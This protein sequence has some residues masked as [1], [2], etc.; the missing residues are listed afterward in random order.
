MKD[1]LRA[2]VRLAEIDASARHIDDQLTG[3]PI[4]LE[5]RRA[6][7]AMLE[8][9][10]GGQKTE[11]DAAEALRSAQEED[12][13]T[14]SD[15]LARSRAKSA[16]A[17]NM[18]EAEA[19][20]RE[21]DAIR[22]SIREG[23]TEKERLEGVIAQTRTVLEVPLRELE[24]QKAELAEAETDV[25]PRLELL[26]EESAEMTKGREQYS[27]VV[28]KPIYRRYERIRF[29]IHPAVVEVI[30]GVC[31]GCRLSISP[32]LQNQILRTDDFYQCQQCQRFLYSKEALL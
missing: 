15:M 26:R 10:V 18:R 9:L 27:G 16:K 20:E 6:A 1:K 24:E 31:Q 25:E 8:E 32:Q 2:L 7:V 13:K 4:E 17:R 14:R 11:M 22:R 29:Q 30:G 19:A 28:P 12:L 21:L 3:I 23:E 5:E